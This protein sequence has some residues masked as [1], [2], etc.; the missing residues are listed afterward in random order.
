[1]VDPLKSWSFSVGMAPA[2]IRAA[3]PPMGGPPGRRMGAVTLCPP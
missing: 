3:G 1:L 2:I